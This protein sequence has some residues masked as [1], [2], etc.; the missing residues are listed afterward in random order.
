M[1]AHKDTKEFVN[2]LT[3]NIDWEELMEDFWKFY[4]EEVLKAEAS[5]TFDLLELV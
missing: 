3:S 1:N 2:S 5:E 4:W